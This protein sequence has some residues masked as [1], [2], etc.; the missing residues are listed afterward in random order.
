ME[1]TRR[2]Y[3]FS[4]L[5]LSLFFLFLVLDRVWFTAGAG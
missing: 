4:T 5:Y 3:K 1:Q 2:L